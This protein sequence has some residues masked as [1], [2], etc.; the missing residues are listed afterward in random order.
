L[1]AG[2]D[3]APAVQKLLDLCQHVGHT[4]GPAGQVL[5]GAVVLLAQDGQQ[6]GQ[7]HVAQQ[8]GDHDVENARH[9]Q[10]DHIALQCR[11]ARRG[12]QVAQVA[13]E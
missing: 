6:E 5:L 1:A 7:H 12:V 13:G 3:A 11:R 9:D 8:E 10:R 4:V 2:R